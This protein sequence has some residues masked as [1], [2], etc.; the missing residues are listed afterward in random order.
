MSSDGNE[1]ELK[2]GGQN[3]DITYENCQEYIELSSTYK[4]NEF[5][6]QLKSIR[7]GLGTL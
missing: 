2:P 1:V 7:K 4:I 6:K 3:I 5:D